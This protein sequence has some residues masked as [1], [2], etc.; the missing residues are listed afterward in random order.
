MRGFLRPFKATQKLIRPR[1]GDGG[2]GQDGAPGGGG[3]ELPLSAL[4]ELE[5]AHD[6][7]V[8]HGQEG[9]AA[10]GI[11]EEL[12]EALQSQVQGGIV[13]FMKPEE[14]GPA[15]PVVRQGPV[16]GQNGKPGEEAL[17]LPPNS[18]GDA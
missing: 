7:A 14:G 11:E 1:L 12:P 8:V 6:L 10:V 15:L 3:G 9:G 16:V 5:Q 2:Q 13:G 18:R 17:A 4:D